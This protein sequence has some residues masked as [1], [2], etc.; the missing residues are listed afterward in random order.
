MANVAPIQTTQNVSSQTPLVNSQNQSA[1]TSQPQLEK[2]KILHRYQRY[3]FKAVAVLLTIQGLV[4]LTKSIDF[5]FFELPELEQRLNLGQIT[6]S[7]ANNFANH[8]IVMT[9]STVLSLFFALRITL[10]QNKIAKG[11]NTAIALLIILGNTQITQILNQFQSGKLLT[12]A[13]IQTFKALLSF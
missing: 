10:T 8:A 13:L 5:I 2:S 7:Q 3:F 6:Q 12:E 4:S 9:I 11:I 1:T